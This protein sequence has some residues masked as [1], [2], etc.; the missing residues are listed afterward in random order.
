MLDFLNQLL[1]SNFMPH[2]HCYFWKPEILWPIVIGDALTVISYF[3]IPLLLIRFLRK[4]KDIKFNFI[5]KLFA[6]FILFCGFGHLIEIINVWEPFYRLSAITK[7]G[8]GVISAGTVFVLFRVFPQVVKI[9]S[10]QELEAANEALKETNEEL[11]QSN[12]DLK[13]AM[14]AAEMGN[15]EVN[16]ETQTIHWSP[17][18]YRIHEVPEGTAL[19]LEDG[20]N[21]YHPEH[22]PIITEAVNKAIETGESWDLELK[23]ITAKKKVVW[24]RAI[25]R[26]VREGS[27]TIKLKGL[28]QDISERKEREQKLESYLAA[29][30]SSNEELQNFAYVASHDLQEPLR[31][32]VSYL[33]LLDVNLG[34]ELDDDGKLYIKNTVNAAS[35]MKK[36]ISDLLALSRLETSEEEHEQIDLNE[37]MSNILRDMEVTIQETNAQ[38]NIDKL[39]Q[40]TGDRV[41]IIQVFQNLIGNAIKF[42]KKGVDPVI[43]I[44]HRKIDDLDEFKIEDNGIGINPKYYDRVFTIF[45]RLHSRSE[46]EGTGIG[47]A[48][49][50]KIIERH[51]GTID[52]E[53]APTGGSIFKFTLASRK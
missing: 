20:I 17:M 39:P 10:P 35:R 5:F 18:I 32:I 24:V 9:P 1:S 47:L 46:Y 45:Q 11:S 12:R 2:G 3:L 51:H 52:I 42:R 21:F 33:Q 41:Q 25:G 26:A 8:T 6:A 13:E 30:K 14:A 4:R 19:T 53:S 22:Q 28:F 49:C 40:I 34:E 31:V 27:K 7:M 23:L 48:I 36:L 38:I 16:L 50:K 15:W 44:S 43:N 37:T 29:L